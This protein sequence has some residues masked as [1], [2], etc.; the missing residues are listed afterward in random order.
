MLSIFNTSDI[1]NVDGRRLDTTSLN[2]KISVTKRNLCICPYTRRVTS[3]DY[4]ILRKLLR[5]MFPKYEYTIDKHLGRWFT[6]DDR[7]KLDWY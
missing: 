7:W 5:W 4:Y 6:T 3:V 1:S 2:D